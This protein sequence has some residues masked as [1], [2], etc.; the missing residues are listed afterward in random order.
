[1][2]ASKAAVVNRWKSNSGFFLQIKNLNEM[3]CEPCNW[4][5][6]VWIYEC[7]SF[8]RKE[9]CLGN[10]SC[11]EKYQQ[12]GGPTQPEEVSSLHCRCYKSTFFGPIFVW[13]E[14]RK[15]KR[16]FP[17][18]L[19]LSFSCWCAVHTWPRL[20][21]ETVQT[22]EQGSGRRIS[23]PGEEQSPPPKCSRGGEEAGL[24]VQDATHHLLQRRGEWRP[25]RF[26]QRLL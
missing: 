1:M 12:L 8:A 9:F 4:I 24:L 26:T 3:N 18:R 25:R 19:P 21:P 17:L 7:A 22:E 15:E 23:H 14:G 6:W 10:K 11:S 5:P 13:I 16:P 20:H 2:K